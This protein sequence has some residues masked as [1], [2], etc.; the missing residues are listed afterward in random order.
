[1]RHARTAFS[2]YQ[3]HRIRLDIYGDRVATMS[4]PLA[5]LPRGRTPLLVLLETRRNLDLAAGFAERSSAIIPAVSRGVGRLL[6]DYLLSN[7][8]RFHRDFYAAGVDPAQ[9]RGDLDS[10]LGA[11]LPPCIA[12]CLERPNDLL[13]RP[14]YLQNLTRLL[15][16]R[17]WNPRR[18]QALVEEAYRRDFGWGDRWGRMDPAWRAEVYVRSFAGL[19]ATGMDRMVDFNCLST[20]EK[21]ICPGVSCGHELLLDRAALF[22]RLAL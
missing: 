19:L 21:G 17:G 7:L 5:T 6:D 3:K 20:Q 1:V 10:L 14:E 15:M 22:E 13:L 4:P 16:S 8:A 12:A 9:A 11:A 2:A 18:I